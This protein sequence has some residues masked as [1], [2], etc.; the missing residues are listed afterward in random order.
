MTVV[1]ASVAFWAPVEIHVPGDNGQV[2]TITTRGRYKRLKKSERIDLHRRIRCN[3][4]LPNH[5]E[6]L[7]KGLEEK[8][9]PLNDHE[10]AEIEAD[11]ATKFISEAEILSCVL[12]DWELRDHKG[13]AIPYTP[14]NLAEQSEAVDGLEA[15]FVR[16]YLKSLSAAD[17][18]G[19][20]EKN[21][22]KQSATT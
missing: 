17:Q 4:M 10:R 9:L 15:A 16:A 3:T 11:V 21:S 20:I 12:V 8:T 5:R 22:G 18:A 14:A 6:L 7:R 2:E 13:E 1:L 19:Q